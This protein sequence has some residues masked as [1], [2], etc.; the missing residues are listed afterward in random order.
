MDEKMQKQIE[1]VLKMD[2]DKIIDEESIVS[3]GDDMDDEDMQSM[4]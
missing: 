4:D 1:T 3:E 2:L